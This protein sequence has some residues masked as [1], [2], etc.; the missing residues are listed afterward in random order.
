MN[1]KFSEAAD[2]IRTQKTVVFLYTNN[3]KKSKEEIKKTISL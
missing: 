3:E 1:N 2:Y